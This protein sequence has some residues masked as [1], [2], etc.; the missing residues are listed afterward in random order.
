MKIN[1]QQRDDNGSVTG[2][3]SLNRAEV[4]VLLQYAVNNFIAMGYV[5][6]AKAVEN[7]DRDDEI[8]FKRA[9]PT[10]ALN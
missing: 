2:E 1:V 9:E 5:F 10:S 6:D 3:F 8:R 4:N 7:D